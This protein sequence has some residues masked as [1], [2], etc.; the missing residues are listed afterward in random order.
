MKSALQG[1]DIAPKGLHA[2]EGIPVSSVLFVPCIE[3]LQ[4]GTIR[5]WAIHPDNPFT[6]RILDV[7]LICISRFLGHFRINQL[8]MAQRSPGRKR[9][10]LSLGRVSM[11]RVFPERR[12]FFAM[13]GLSRRNQRRENKIE[14][15]VDGRD[16]NPQQL[17][18][19]SLV[20]PFKP[21]QEK[22]LPAPVR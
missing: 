15:L 1:T 11:S 3:L 18:Y 19:S 22:R 17:G 8:P 21:V 2:I 16:A 20:H 7:G 5:I 12:Y 14:I 10:H 13:K 9:T 4:I 6:S